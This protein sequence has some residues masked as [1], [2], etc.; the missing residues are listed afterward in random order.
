MKK[1][2]EKRVRLRWKGTLLL[3]AIFFLGSVGGFFNY[4]ESP[5]SYPLSDLKN[6]DSLLSYRFGE[7]SFWLFVEFLGSIIFMLSLFYTDKEIKKGNSAR[8]YWLFNLVS[9]PI[10]SI[11]VIFAFLNLLTSP[12]DPFFGFAAFY[13]FAIPFLL[14]PF[15]GLFSILP[16]YILIWNY[17][18][19]PQKLIFYGGLIYL[20]YLIISVIMDVV[21]IF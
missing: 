5:Y 3:F 15:I 12:N 10:L 6:P 2:E 9:W 8:K 21:N 13:S 7:S 16:R 20:V 4:L 17:K 11:I 1:R 14:I 19:K 18:E